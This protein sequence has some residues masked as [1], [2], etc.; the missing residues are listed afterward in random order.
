MRPANARVSMPASSSP[1]LTTWS[2]AR[3][4]GAIRDSQ[5]T[6]SAPASSHT[7]RSSSRLSPW[8]RTSRLPRSRRSASR[9]RSDSWSHQ[10]WAPPGA[11]SPCSS[12][13]QTNTGTTG[14]RSA[15]WTSAA[16]SRR[17]RSFR[18][19]TTV[20]DMAQ[21]GG[22]PPTPCRPAAVPARR[23]DSGIAGFA[24]L[25]PEAGR[26][27]SPRAAPRPGPPRS[28][29][30]SRPAR[31]RARRRGRSASARGRTRS[32]PCRPGR[33]PTSQASVE[34][35]RASRIGPVATTTSQP[36]AT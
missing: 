22:P 33:P 6:R 27:R 24:H 23:P 17:R 5:T 26:A 19:Q 21:R 13:A 31:T 28:G 20:A 35:G 10:R 9:A 29:R 4:A 12:G 18:N 1:A 8:R 16:W 25:G 36:I 2:V 14:P 15:A 7:A 32:R 30:R 34:P 3:S 11:Q